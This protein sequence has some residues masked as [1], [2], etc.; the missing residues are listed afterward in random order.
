MTHCAIPLLN[1]SSDIVVYVIILT[2]IFSYC[3]AEAENA[4]VVGGSFECLGLAIDNALW[5]LFAYL[6]HFRFL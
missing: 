3:G 1:G 6:L 5:V 4:P 2:F